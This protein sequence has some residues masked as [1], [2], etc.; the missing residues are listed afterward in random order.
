M[1]NSSRPVLDLTEVRV[2]N[3]NALTIILGFARDY[4]VLYDIWQQI[5]T[6]LNEVPDLIREINDLRT[7]L[8]N[9]RLDRANLIA[10]VRATLAAHRDGE[11]DPLFYLHDELDVQ[12][13]PEQGGPR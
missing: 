13:T 11:R 10:A 3:A 5:D 9:V 2:R 12:E 4:P 1:N 6:A 7:E 8:A